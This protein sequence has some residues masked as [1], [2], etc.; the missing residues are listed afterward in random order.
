[1]R[2]LSLITLALLAAS[3]VSGDEATAEATAEAKKKT[4]STKKKLQ[5]GVKKRVEDCKIRSRRGDSL[6][7]HYTVRREKKV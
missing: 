1:M 3:F 4:A 6:H 2:V 7:M 5:I